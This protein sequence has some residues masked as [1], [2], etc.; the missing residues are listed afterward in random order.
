MRYLRE[1]REPPTPD[2][3]CVVAACC[4]LFDLAPTLAGPGRGPGGRVEGWQ[5][6]DAY[7]QAARRGFLGDPVLLDHIANFDVARL[8]SLAWPKARA[9]VRRVERDRSSLHA[10]RAEYSCFILYSW[11]RAV[12]GIA[13]SIPNDR[14][15]ST[16]DDER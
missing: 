16:N 2:I 10:L 4:V 15:R 1:R 3:A 14:A 5:E 12:L 8:D 13:E 7:W 11:A 6:L 9:F